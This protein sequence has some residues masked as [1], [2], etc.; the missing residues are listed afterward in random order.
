M[1][2]GCIITLVKHIDYFALKKTVQLLFAFRN[3][4]KAHTY[5]F[6]SLL[7]IIIKGAS[8]VNFKHKTIYRLPSSHILSVVS[9]ERREKRINAKINNLM[10][11]SS[12]LHLEIT[13]HC[14]N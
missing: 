14:Q 10:I 11:I 5:E 8:N 4:Y 12:I 1:R 3:K 13:N 9:K 6:N 7:I 2:Y